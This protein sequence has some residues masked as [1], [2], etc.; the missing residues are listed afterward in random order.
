MLVALVRFLIEVFR[1]IYQSN[2][3]YLLTIIGE[4]PLRRQLADLAYQYDLPIAFTGKLAREKVLD[5]ISRHS[6]MVHTSTKES[7]SFALLEA[8]ILGLHTFASSTLAILT[9]E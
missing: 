2:S 6:L 4:C 1:L 7:F 3:K 8:K 9:P 5:T